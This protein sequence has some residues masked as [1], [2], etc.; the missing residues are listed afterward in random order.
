[1]ISLNM[2]C[3]R[4]YDVFSSDDISTNRRQD[5]CATTEGYIKFDVDTK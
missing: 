2:K 4:Q 5:F 1:M 3:L